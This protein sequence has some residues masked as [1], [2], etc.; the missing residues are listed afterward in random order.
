[1]IMIAIAV[2]LGI[3]AGLFIPYNLS[4]ASL[5]YVAVIILAAL[6]TIFGGFWSYLEKRFKIAMFVSGLI[7]NAVVAVLF[8]FMG[9]KLGIDLSLAVIVVFGVRIFNN[10]S[11]IRRYLFERYYR[12]KNIQ[13]KA[14]ESAVEYDDKNEVKE[15]DE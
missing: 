8:T 11:S 1:M 15:I 5:H 6:D 2:L 4:D 9:D 3:L 7:S 12:A 13:Q 10:L 14:L